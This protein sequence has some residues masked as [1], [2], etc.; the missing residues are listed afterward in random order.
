[1]Q[2]EQIEQALK[3]VPFSIILAQPSW[4]LIKMGPMGPVA[5][6]GSM[7]VYIQNICPLIGEV[8]E[9]IVFNALFFDNVSIENP[10]FLRVLFH[11]LAHSTGHESRLNRYGVQL[12]PKP[13]PDKA[14]EE[15]VAERTSQKAMVHFGIYDELT[16]RGSV[17]YIS[18]YLPLF[19]KNGTKLSGT[20]SD[21]VESESDKALDYMLRNWFNEINPKRKAA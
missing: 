19:A 9:S 18:Q 16:F 5:L 21:L 12:G 6:M 11:E 2:K 13:E 3:K 10:M 4:F 7:A 1:M 15:L 20:E 17:D 14:L 8:R